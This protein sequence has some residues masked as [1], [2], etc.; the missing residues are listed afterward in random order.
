MARIANYPS[1][2][3]D[4]A[5]EIAQEVDKLGGKTTPQTLADKLNKK[6]SGSFNNDINASVKHGLISK[7]QDTLILTELYNNIKLSYNEEEKLHHLQQAF[8]IPDT[9]REIL[10]QFDGK[11]L[12][13][14]VLDKILMREY[15]VV[16]GRSKTVTNNILK[17]GTKL[18][19][20]KEGVV[21]LPK[22]ITHDLPHIEENSVVPENKVETIPSEKLKSQVSTDQQN[23]DASK[24]IPKGLDLINLQKEVVININIQLSVPETTNE[25]VYEKFFSAM[26]R[27]LLS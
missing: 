14:S 21:R 11:D 18:E 26:K 20:I 2:S 25:E 23:P 4:T 8:L 5:L 1:K 24:T 7:N 9:Y 16:E 3:F 12:P 10:E 6:V 19:L 22:N 17:G 13:T 27:N 15:Q